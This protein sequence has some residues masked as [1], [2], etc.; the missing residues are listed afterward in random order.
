[1]AATL[2]VCADLAFNGRFGTVFVNFSL[3]PPQLRRT[4]LRA[5]IVTRVPLRHNANGSMFWND[6]QGAEAILQVRAA[7]LCDDDRL[8]H[9]LRTRPGCAYVRRSTVVAAA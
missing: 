7:A 6:P 5:T 2:R 1:M 9:Y 8:E 3:R 4:L